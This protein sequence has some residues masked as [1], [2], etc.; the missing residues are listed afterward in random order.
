MKTLL[1]MIALI[2]SA[3]DMYSQTALTGGITQSG[4]FTAAGQTA[5]YAYNQ[6]VSYWS[7]VGIRPPSTSDF[8]IELSANTNFSPTLASSTLG[9]GKVDFIVADYNH[10][11]TGAQYV[12]LK[13]YSGAGTYYVEYESGAHTLGVPSNSGTL[14]WTSNEIVKVWDVYLQ[15]GVTYTFKLRTL[16]GLQDYGI[17]LYKSNT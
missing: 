2:F 16:S 14:S 9:T 7:V 8:D 10:S 17:S 15:A 6:S 4:N 3:S 1:T 11:P 12:R 13:D 5:T